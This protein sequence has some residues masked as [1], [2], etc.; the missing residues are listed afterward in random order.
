MPPAS[1]L[2]SLKLALINCL[3]HHRSDSHRCETQA[4]HQPTEPIYSTNQDKNY[5]SIFN[6]Q[7]S[8]AAKSQC[9]QTHIMLKKRNKQT[10][11]LPA[12]ALSLC[13]YV[14]L[15]YFK[16]ECFITAKLIVCGDVV[17]TFFSC[18]NNCL[19]Q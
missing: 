11:T 6:F 17:H 9:A 19:V 5:A 3:S 18:T 14:N 15:Y 13:W 1:L 2:S 10:K 4:S 8:A 16:Y 7:M 12:R